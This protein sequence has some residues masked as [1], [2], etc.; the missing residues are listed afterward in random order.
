MRGNN[1]KEIWKWWLFCAILDPMTDKEL[2]DEWPE[3]YED[4]FRTP[5]GKLVKEVETELILDLLDPA[6]GE[7]ILDAGCGTGIFTM[8][9]LSRGARVTGLD[10]SVPMLELAQKKMASYPF[11]AVRGDIRQLPFKDNSFDKAT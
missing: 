6:P 8:D 3:R 11:S 9:F 5:I 2:F 4:W 10:I 7:N 1:V